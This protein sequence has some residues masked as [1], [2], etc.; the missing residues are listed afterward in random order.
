MRIEVLG[1][2]RLSTDEGA[3]VPVAER[4]LRLLLAAL[5]AA[6]GEPVP[7]DTL[8]ERLW[9]TDLP[10]NPKRVLATKLSRLRTLLDRAGP[11][12]RALL[13]TTPAGYRLAAHR[14]D[15]DAAAFELALTRAR[16]APAAHRVHTLREALALWRGQPYGDAADELWLAP[17][18]AQLN[19]RHADALQLLIEALIEE[20][21]HEQAL[22][23]LHTALAH[24]PLR[25]PLIGALM[26]A[27]YRADR[28]QEALEIFASLQQRLSAELG[29]DPS[30]HL[31]ELHS[32]ILRQDP[33]LAPQPR[34]RSAARVGTG[35][36]HVPAPSA[37]LIGRGRER[38]EI[39]ALL[40]SAR[41]VT[42]TGIGGV[43]KTR[44]A[45]HLA[46]DHQ[47]RRRRGVWFIDLTELV[48]TAATSQ[49]TSGDRIAALA[50]RVLALTQRTRHTSD[51]DRLVD[52][53]G[54]A[55]ALLVL[56][57]CEHVTAEAAH[58][59]AALLERAPGAQILATSREPLGVVAEQRYDLPT[60]RTEPGELEPVSEAVEFF[61]ARAQAT[62]PAFTLDENT[63]PAIA[64]LC[65]RLDG[66]PLA[67]ELAAARVRG[68]SVPD[69]L[70]RLSDRLNLLRRPGGPMPRRQQTLRGMIDWSWSLLDEV[71]QRV[72]RRLAV[73]SGSISL[74]AAEVI[75][76]DDDDDARAAVGPGQVVDALLA[77]V[78][79]SMV[80]AVSTPAG[81]RYDLLESIAAFAGEKL[82]T[83]GESDDVAGRHL[84]Y[85]VAFARQADGHLRGPEQRRWLMKLEAER[86]QLRHAVDYAARTQDGA[87]AAALA[88][89]TF[90]YQWIFGRLQGLQQDLAQAVALPGPRDDHYAAA[91][92]LSAC[93][94]LPDQSGRD[95]QLVATALGGFAQD[96]VARARVQW[97]AGASLLAVGVREAGEHHIEE[98][99]AILT[100]A[101][102]DWD[103]AIAACQRDW[104]L[105]SNWGETP[106]GLPDGRDPEQILTDLGDGYGLAQ[107]YDVAH[108]SAEIDGDH[109]RA[110]EAAH[111]A[112]QVC[113]D[114]ELWAEATY[115][116]AATAV[117]ALRSGDVARAT[118]EVARARS[119]AHD[120][121]GGE[122]SSQY[123][124]F[125]DAMIARYDGDLLRARASLER[126]LATGGL[127]ASRDPAAHLESGFLAVQ[128][129]DLDRAEE[130]YRAVH[131]LLA[132][133]AGVPA[134][135]RGLEL[136]A[137]I[138][139]LRGQ[140]DVAAELLGT[141]EAHRDRSNLPAPT[142]VR[143][144]LDRVRNVIDEH[145]PGE[146]AAAAF[147]RGWSRDPGTQ[148]QAV[149]PD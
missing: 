79:R 44:L 59:V 11:G 23:H 53:L 128:Q 82:H 117:A 51:T 14:A 66:L 48:P 134:I 38:E 101:G 113:L 142:L 27:L 74:A 139:A 22:D 18:I 58:F 125:V 69:L 119:L 149:A 60:L 76:A 73:H 77:L 97:F 56:D 86:T 126:L 64:E 9:H 47:V 68:I 8:S 12:G 129:H 104:F 95:A 50:A 24:H 81:V 89:A 1:P 5:V 15:V 63:A 123:V 41:L 114:Y 140:V 137:A 143:R 107:V 131:R 85:Y 4:H 120:V 145:L 61:V 84:H 111:R 6:D 109:L 147:N 78:D 103:V 80:R 32:R 105:V 132:R 130:A 70:D 102:A 110:A 42:L 16:S 7:A 29:V 122:H 138:R 33:G 55:P 116:Y 83:A 99:T 118:R 21:H 37:S 75:C 94:N 136:A 93:M 127:E 87:S 100:R 90:W 17:A 20:G 146:Q 148:F 19:A 67:L 135:A 106:R 141:A 2:V 35:R 13:E 39:T 31:R 30:P 92:T 88:V 45:L 91:A 26:L 112:L 52:A 62:D 57:N 49:Q 10:A 36:S 96:D 108:R 25:E 144:D 3:Q 133:R 54:C 40:D 98:A 71:Q 115:W 34:R 46:Q 124:D 72:L 43:G 65:R 28:Q 121:A